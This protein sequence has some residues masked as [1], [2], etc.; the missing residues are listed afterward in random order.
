MTN[1][2]K[3]C[4]I[5]KLFYKK[6]IEKSGTLYIHASEWDKYAYQ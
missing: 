1:V 5:E 2:I 4:K 6:Y 3:M